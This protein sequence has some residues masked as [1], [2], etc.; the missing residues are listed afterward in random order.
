MD[1]FDDEDV[2]SIQSDLAQVGTQSIDLAGL[3]DPVFSESG[4]FDLSL[5]RSSALGRILDALPVAALLINSS[6][7]VSFANDACTRLDDEIRHV[8]GKPFTELLPRPRNAEKILT[9]LDRAFTTREPQVAEAVLQIDARKIWGRVHLRSVRIGLERQALCLVEDLTHEKTQLALK[10]RHE[11]EIRKTWADLENQVKQRTKE[12]ALTNEKLRGEIGEHQRTQEQLA[13]Q[14]RKFFL[15][16]ECSPLGM[17]MVDQND[18]T[19]YVN[20]KFHSLFG[21]GA[22]DCNRGGDLLKAIH[23]DVDLRYATVAEWFEK[24]RAASQHETESRQRTVSCRDGTEKDVEVV[25]VELGNNDLLVTLEDVTAQR[26]AQAMMLKSER[27]NAV[28]E[29]AAG[30]AHNF[31]NLLQMVIGSAEQALVNLDSS[32]VF[33]AQIDINHILLEASL[34]MHTVKRLQTF[35]GARFH[36]EDDITEVVDLSAIAAQA[37]EMTS[38]WW[39][40]VAEKAGNKIVFSRKLIP[41]CVTRGNRGELFEMAVNLIKNAAEALPH[42]G[43]IEVETSVSDDWVLLRVKD[44]GVGISQENLTKVFEPFWTTKGDKGTGIG[45]ASAFGIANAHQGGISVE[46]IEGAGATFTTRLPLCTEVASSGK[47][48]GAVNPDQ[49]LSVLV[50]DDVQSIVGLLESG[51]GRMGH[52]VYPAFSGTEALEAFQREKIDL[53]ICDL[54]MPHMNGWQVAEAIQEICSRRGERKV[55]F[56]LMT[57][58]GR[59]QE[60]KHEFM[61][62]SAVDR[63]LTKPLNLSELVSAMSDLNFQGVSLSSQ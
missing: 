49:K 24:V 25:V 7:R 50:V 3:L 9:L 38:P 15:L 5:V 57:G 28:T 16:A 35:A 48:Q 62:S 37:I 36:E 61:E 12:L 52:L 17:A 32:H 53:V 59:S 58:W 21:Y 1:W 31:N 23:L 6:Y 42:G 44:D 60:L 14:S 41:G 45:L 47:P 20:P 40:T 19:Q 56:I 11:E 46:S 34:G 43:L 22:Q 2:P 13:L 63:V 27:L 29:M 55:P 10:K 30:A 54:G 4:S 26:K 33:E 51:L 18:R 39:K 8:V